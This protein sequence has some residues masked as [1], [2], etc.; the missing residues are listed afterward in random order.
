MEVIANAMVLIIVQYV[1]ISNQHL[2][3][4]KLY[5]V[6]TPIIAQWKKNLYNLSNE[7]NKTRWNLKGKYKDMNLDIEKLRKTRREETWLKRSL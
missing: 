5:N 3:T 2:Y 4:L 7:Q 1:N 6:Y